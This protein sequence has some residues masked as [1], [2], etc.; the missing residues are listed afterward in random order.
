MLADAIGGPPPEVPSQWRAQSEWDPKAGVGYITTGP[1]EPTEDFSQ[2]I[3]KFGYNPETTEISGGIGQWQK[4]QPDGSWLASY[5]FKIIPREKSLDLPSLYAASRRSAP[6]RIKTAHNPVGDVAVIAD[7]QAGKVAARG[8]TPELL[9]RLALVRVELAER[10]KR[11]KPERIFLPDVGDLV[12]NFESGGNPMRTNDLSLPQQLDVAATEI[13]EFVRLASKYAPV[14]VATVPS[15]H[16]AWRRGKQVLGTPDDDW[17]IHVHRQ[18]QKQA[19]LLGLDATWHYPASKFDESVLVEFYGNRIGI[20]H[21]NQF[22]PGGAAEWWS[23]QQ[24]GGQATATADILLTGHYHCLR[25]NPDGHNPYTKR[26]KW[27]LQAPTL[28][29]GSDWY[30][31]KAGDDSDPGLLCFSVD[32]NGLSLRSL[33]VL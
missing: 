5:H 32:A 20:V 14:D 1:T 28:D 3:T 23:R 30:R 16:G 8:G 29:G 4:E 7:V 26:T 9:E 11:I 13:F 18:V 17:G 19:Q 31:S 22:A 12:E 10:W 2:F 33:D 6:K 25:V 27:W 24:H 21:G 15:N